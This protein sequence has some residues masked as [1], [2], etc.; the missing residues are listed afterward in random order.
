MLALTRPEQADDT[1]ADDA[2]RWVGA[3]LVVDALH[4]LRALRQALTEPG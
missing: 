3:R 2:R 4:D 1:W